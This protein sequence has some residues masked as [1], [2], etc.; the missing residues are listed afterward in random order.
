MF[1]D[2]IQV[3]VCLRIGSN[4]YEAR[5]YPLATNSLMILFILK[6]SGVPAAIELIRSL[7][8]DWKFPDGITPIP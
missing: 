6:R 3:A 5:N 4:L 2:P 7:R 1:D 8:D